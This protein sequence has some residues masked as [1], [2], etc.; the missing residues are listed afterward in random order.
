MNKVISLHGGPTGERE[1]SQTCVE[2]L[3]ELLEQAKSGEVVG[4]VVASVHHDSVSSFDIAGNVVLAPMI[5]AM[6]IAKHHL[7]MLGRGE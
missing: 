2:A 5:G 1:V 7:L 6:E 3:E 4:I